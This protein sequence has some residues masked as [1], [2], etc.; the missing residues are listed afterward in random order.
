MSASRI[1][2]KTFHYLLLTSA[3]NA[4]LVDV[5]SK[6]YSILCK[7]SCQLRVLDGKSSGDHGEGVC[8]CEVL[9][10]GNH[11]KSNLIFKEKITTKLNLSPH[12][13][14][15]RLN[16]SQHIYNREIPLNQAYLQKKFSLEI[17]P[18]TYN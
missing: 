12:I 5:L 10:F 18:V 8:V 11:S 16:L 2:R 6:L 4:K 15:L 9:V 14:N 1:L 7:V 17:D 13:I 3:S